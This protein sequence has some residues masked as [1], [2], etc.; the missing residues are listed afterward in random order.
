MFLTNTDYCTIIELFCD[1][2]VHGTFY[3]L[4]IKLLFIIMLS[5]KLSDWVNLLTE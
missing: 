5:K 1:C 4:K 3:F 2:N